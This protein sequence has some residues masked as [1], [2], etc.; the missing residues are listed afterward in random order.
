[1]NIKF[2]N[3]TILII[4]HLPSKEKVKTKEV[5][6][7]RNGYMIDTS[8]SVDICEKVET[9]GKVIENCDSVIYWE[10]FKLSPFRKDM[11]KIFDLGQK[12]KHERN[13]LMQIMVKPV[14]NC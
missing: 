8:T 2:Y 14:M 1:M 4:Q 13:D 11:K 7:T 10:N 5:D 12:Y 3:Q 6:R 9:G